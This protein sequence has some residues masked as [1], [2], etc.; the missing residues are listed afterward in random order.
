MSDIIIHNIR[1][2][3]DETDERVRNFVKY[4]KSE[5]RKEELRSYYNKARNEE[6]DGQIYLS[7]KSGNE[8]NLECTGEHI[9]HLNLRGF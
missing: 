9:C 6:G 4:L 2:S 1:I 5:D 8:F 3:Y 7:D